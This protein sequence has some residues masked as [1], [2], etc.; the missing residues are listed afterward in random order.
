MNSRAREQRVLKSHILSSKRSQ[1][2]QASSSSP[3][4][5]RAQPSFFS[6]QVISRARPE[7]IPNTNPHH[8]FRD[9]TRRFA[10]GTLLC[11]KNKYRSNAYAPVPTASA[12][13]QL[14]MQRWLEGRPASRWAFSMIVQGYTEV[15]WDSKHAEI[16]EVSGLGAHQRLQSPK[17]QVQLG[18]T[19][20]TRV[21]L[22]SRFVVF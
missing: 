5:A 13:P 15:S 21:L 19:L 20:A 22:R 8:P 18:S 17:E 12:G 1:A 14:P 2:L 6:N 11:E 16:L 9:S 4:S 10:H 3:N 7:T